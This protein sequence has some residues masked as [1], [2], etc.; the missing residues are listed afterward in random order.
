MIPNHFW[1]SIPEP[2][3]I[4]AKKILKAHKWVSKVEKIDI[5]W[6]NCDS[7]TEAVQFIVW[8]PQEEY[9]KL[10][11]FYRDEKKEEFWSVRLKDSFTSPYMLKD[12]TYGGFDLLGLYPALNE[13]TRKSVEKKK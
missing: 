2:Y 6:Y 1:A 11:R 5:P 8:L 12:P 13:K 3:E 7:H 10:I 9:D 4:I